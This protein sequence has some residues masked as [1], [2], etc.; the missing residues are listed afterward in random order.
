MEPE[1]LPLLR[2]GAHLVPED[3]ACLMEYVSVLA[4]ERFTDSPRCTDS[5]LS[6]LAR[7]VNDATSDQARPRLARFAPALAAP[8]PWRAD[9]APA[10]TAAVL[11]QA[12]AAPTAGRAVRRHLRRAHRRLRRTRTA[13]AQAGW[14]KLTDAV[15]RRGPAT[16]ALTAAVRAALRLPNEQRD[17]LLT[18]LLATGLAAARAT[19]GTR[20]DSHVVDLCGRVL[21]A[22]T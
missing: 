7:L 3:G 18:A 16:H 6:V 22:P 13:P 14:E 2:P 8:L 17:A 12:T 10:V 21:P 11:T 9:L 19:T 1:S 4:G 20:P 5:L 15:Y